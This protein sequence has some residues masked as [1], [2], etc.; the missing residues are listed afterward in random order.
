MNQNDRRTLE[1]Q[2]TVMG[3]PMLDDPALVQVIADLVNGFPIVNERVEFF[4]D[5]LNECEGA[6]R[7]EMYE[8]MRPR[9]HFDVPSLDAC[10]A[11]IAAKAERLIRPDKLGAIREFD[12]LTEKPLEIDCKGCGKQEHFAGMT[13]ADAMA[14]ARKAGWGRGPI[15]FEEYCADCRLAA[16][17][18]NRLGPALT[19][20]TPVVGEGLLNG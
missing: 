20:R 1:N 10:E 5:L 14:A 18:P 8:A 15:P 17:L 7:R 2:L 4:C 16:M 19:R 3:L 6:R 13:T 12:E 11:R 9:L